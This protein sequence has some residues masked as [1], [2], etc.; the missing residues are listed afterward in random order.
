MRILQ[1]DVILENC[2]K[3]SLPERFVDR[4]MEHEIATGNLTSSG[5]AL[6]AEALW[7]DD[8]NVAKT[9]ART[10]LTTVRDVMASL[11]FRNVINW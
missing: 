3:R 10:Q 6:C 1:V 5:F 11:L 8:R 4:A 9:N 2:R 7:V